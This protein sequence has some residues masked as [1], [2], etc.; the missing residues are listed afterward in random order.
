VILFGLGVFAIYKCW[1]IHTGQKAWL[2]YGFGVVI[3]ADRG[4]ESRV[5]ELCV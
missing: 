4:L 5:V 2:E 3:D 1:T